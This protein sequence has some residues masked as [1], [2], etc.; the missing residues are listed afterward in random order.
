MNSLEVKKIVGAALLGGMVALVTGIL[1]TKLTEPRHSESA[2][3]S[4]PEG[5]AEPTTTEPAILEPVSPLLATADIGAGETLFKKCATC[6]TAEKGGPK[7]VGPNL[8][9]IVGAP[10]GHLADFAYSNGLKT[11]GGNWDYESLNAW[12]AAPKSFIP[13]NKMAFAGLKKVQDRAN[14]IAWLRTQNDSPPALPDQAAIDAAAAA[15][16]QATTETTAAVATTSSDG[17]ATSTTE[18]A[19]TASATTAEQTASAPTSSIAELL[20]TADAAAGKQVA[21]KCT[22]CHSFDKGGPNKV[23][24]NLWDIVGAKQARAADYS[25]TDAIRNLGGEWTYEDLDMYLTSPKTFAPGTKMAFAGVK[26]PEDRAAL[27]AFLRT[28]SDSPKPLP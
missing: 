23:G 15:A 16:A 7:K 13:G 6:H 24:P 25:Y 28:L 11:K 4:L 27:I 12:L 18:T 1:A 19:A 20:K 21:K 17:S 10:L 2:A 8:W 26:K 3:I 14:L 22:A 5:G 9:G